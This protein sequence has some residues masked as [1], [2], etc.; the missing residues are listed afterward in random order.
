MVTASLLRRHPERVAL[1]L[2]RR[3]WDAAR[4]AALQEQTRA[5]DSDP[6]LATLADTLPNL[7]AEDVPPQ[8][9]VY[10]SSGS[11]A[12]PP[13]WQ[14]PH[15]EVLKAL[16]MLDASRGTAIAATRFTLLR[17][18]AALL[19]HALLHWMITLHVTHHGYE[20]ISP[21][22]VANTMTLRQTGHLPHFAAD[23]YAL[24]PA[25][26]DERGL[27]LN[28]T[29]EVPL[30]AL[31]AGELLAESSLPRAYVAGIPSFR[32][33]AGSVGRQTRGLLRLHQFPKVELV[34]C[35]TP[36]QS[37]DAFE[38]M[39]A[40]ACTVLAALDIAYR[41]IDLPGP[42]LGFAAARGRDV[43]AWFVGMGEWIEVASIADCT[44]F[45]SRRANIRYKP[46]Q[47]GRPRF[48]HTLNA[49][50]LAVG[51]TLAALV[52]R[53]QTPEGDFSVPELLW[54]QTP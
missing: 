15:W 29:A 14:R 52:E 54:H 31:H 6:E 21:P 24:A 42:D 37:P 48:V 50:G 16:G 11:P 1:G 8:R 9:T 7:P 22:I 47:G 19:E 51:R 13:T 40:H 25:A 33:E 4:I 23:M 32:R 10:L 41:V 45:Q 5:A 30:V 18:R 46:G 26:D 12:A 43:E 53:Y 36:E 38:A 3:G 20:P 2:S 34:R 28:P 39:T 17:G 44:T 27:W 35:T 49:S